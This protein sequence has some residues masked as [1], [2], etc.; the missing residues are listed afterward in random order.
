MAVASPSMNMRAREAQ[1][2]NN[3]L[4]SRHW[5]LAFISLS[6]VL[7][8]VPYL[9][10]LGLNQLQGLL[11]PMAATF[12]TTVSD[13]SR[14]IVNATV[15]L[16]IGG[17]HMYA[18]FSRTALDT[19]YRAKHPRI[20][21]TSLIIPVI[22]ISLAILSLEILLTVFF[23]WASVHVLHQIV[24]ITE[25]YNHRATPE[26]QKF[27]TFSRISDYAVIMTSL[28]PIAA[29]K[30]SIGAFQIGRNDLNSVIESV[31]G[32]FGLGLGPWMWMLAGAMFAVALTVWIVKTV[33]E[34]RGGQ[35]HPA[36]TLFIGLTVVASFFVP[37]LG[38]LDTAF[39]GMNLWHSF[40]YLAL[41]WMLNN[42]RRERGE[43]EGSPLVDRISSDGSARKYYLFNMG[44][45][46]AD[47]GL[48]V[49]FFFIMVGVFGATFDFAFDRAY[50]MAVLS[51]L[52]IHYYHDHFL[53]TEPEV[54]RTSA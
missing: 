43:L 9:S 42:L 20:L 17:P 16:L 5:D 2:N 36:K 27:F 25:L 53:F 13:L 18:T 19:E 49:V 31:L 12:G 46:I 51:F 15:A 26:K 48:A 22:V 38:N 21:W 23:F 50:Y 1:H 33:I 3:W 47:V 29:Y 8:T 40:Q 54:I 52:W 44:L 24:Y 37:A 34:W 14:N 10:Y 35:L 7:V 45:T 39:Q 41:T 32:F 6:V 11:S 30:M 4:H 28:Y